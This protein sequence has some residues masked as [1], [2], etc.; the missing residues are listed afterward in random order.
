MDSIDY[1]HF[2]IMWSS[3]SC[4]LT[5]FFSESSSKLVKSPTVKYVIF[6]LVLFAGFSFANSFLGMYNFPRFDDLESQPLEFY[7]K[8]HELSELQRNVYM[9]A[10]ETLSL[11]MCLIIP[12]WQKKYTDRISYLQSRLKEEEEH[13]TR[14]IRTSSDLS[15]KSD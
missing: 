1:L 14:L 8:K 10:I 9:Q 5:L 4:A 15:K 13:Y 2:L 6:G 12:Q 7:K 11:Y 3:T